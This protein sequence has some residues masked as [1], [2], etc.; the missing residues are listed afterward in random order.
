MVPH[1][2]YLGVI[3]VVP[4]IPY[5]GVMDVVD[6]ALYSAYLLFGW[7]LGWMRCLISPI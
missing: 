6:L 1:I 7:E 4:H 3:D 2:S 5:L